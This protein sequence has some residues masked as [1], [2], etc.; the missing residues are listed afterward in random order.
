[1]TGPKSGA[2]KKA[3]A[4][5][6]AAYAAAKAKSDA[7]ELE[8]ECGECEGK[9]YDKD[10]F[11]CDT[12]CGSG[13]VINPDFKGAAELEVIRFEAFQIAAREIEETETAEL[14]DRIERLEAAHRE[15]ER[16]IKDRSD[17]AGTFQ[18]DPKLAGLHRAIEIIKRATGDGA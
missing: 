12:C 4:A 16:E 13:D 5:A 2:F 9:G 15:I 10:G 3:V 1:M 7:A 11:G 6:N 18:E 8:I 14:L 17:L